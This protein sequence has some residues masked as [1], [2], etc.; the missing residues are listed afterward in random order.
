MNTNDNTNRKKPGIPNRKLRRLAPRFVRV[1][2]KWQGDSP[3]VRAIAEVGIDAARRFIALYDR[4]ATQRAQRKREFEEDRRA[5]TALSRS[6]REW[7]AV[8]A[9]HVDIDPELY[10]ASVDIP[11]DVV[12]GAE[13]LLHL[14]SDEG[15][16]R[17]QPFAALMIDA[18]T[19]V[20][21]SAQREREEARKLAGDT[22]ETA[23]ALRESARELQASL[24]Q[25]RRVLRGRFGASHLDYQSLR[26]SRVRSDDGEAEIVDDAVTDAETTATPDAIDSPEL[27]GTSP[28]GPT[29]SDN[30]S[31]TF[32][33][34]PEATVG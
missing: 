25:L 27:D 6:V 9:P 1:C 23:W 15:P 12:G 26:A 11:D 18:I 22:Q 24:K 34:P 2:E 28:G 30:G 33:V 8:V 10:V 7:V 19:P 5:V 20:L 14:V 32:P 3:A 21:E 31:G 17:D 13:R 4:F 29:P 16:L